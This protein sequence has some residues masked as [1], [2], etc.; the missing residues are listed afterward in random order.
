MRQK[1][2]SKQLTITLQ[3]EVFDHVQKETDVRGMSFSEWFR[4]AALGKI[5]KDKLNNN[6]EEQNNE[7]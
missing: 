2:F 3:Q 4:D 5:D 7:Y 6:M 1:K